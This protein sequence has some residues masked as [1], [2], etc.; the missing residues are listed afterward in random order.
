MASIK[1]ILK[2]GK[3]YK[4]GKHPIV[5]RILHQQIQK[6][7]SLGLKASIE[8]WNEDLSRFTSKVKDYKTKN[9]LLEHFESRS[10]YIL[11]SFKK[12]N[13]PF[14]FEL[15][16]DRFW[17]KDKDIS[18]FAFYE[19]KI[20]ELNTLQKINTLKIY[21]ASY[22]SLK[23]FRKNVD[24]SFYEINYDFIRQYEAFLFNN[25][26]TDGGVHHHMR[27]LRAIFN[28]VIR[29]KYID[30]SYYPFSTQFNKEGYS[31][32]HLKSRAAPRA[33]SEEDI[34]KFKK[35]NISDYPD[36]TNAYYY[37]LFSYYARGIN[38]VD[39][40][41]LKK[42][43]IYDNR[44]IYNRS[45][46][47]KPLNIKVSKNILSILEYFENTPPPYIFPILSEKHATESQKKHRIKKTL[48]AFNSDL[49]KIATILKINVNLTSYVA[50]HTY[51]TTLKRNGISTEII[52]ESLGHSE[53]ATTK[54]YLE[55]FSN[56]H[57]DKSDELL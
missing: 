12:E 21:K 19:V 1:I 55:K 53:L 56:E 34:D 28:E 43:D 45:K 3:K 29:R 51:A 9:Q 40:A 35:L 33:L 10:E 46:T 18:L 49:K 50:R 5:L 54:A 38:Y 48:R 47:S 7:A 57:L 14:S 30:S 25:G 26:N 41:L 15:F 24:I 2:K 20:E 52:S 8:E 23:K 6:I 39:M 4:D 17:G 11:N 32:S 13:K 42:S 31:L 27:S 22:N 44:L 36:L 37:F 16:T